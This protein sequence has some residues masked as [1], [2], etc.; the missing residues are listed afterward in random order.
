[1]S[2]DKLQEKIR[3][4]K[5]PTMMELSLS[6]WDIPQ[7]VRSQFESAA[8]AYGA[9]CEM[10]L[11]QMKGWIPGIRV[12]FSSFALLGEEGN[13]QLSRILK[14]ASDCGYYVLLD[15]PEIWSAESAELVIRQIWGE[16][17]LFPC[18][19]V[20]IGCYLGSDIYKPFLPFCEK[21]K[22]DLF[23]SVRSSNKSASEL[24]DLLAGSRLV[25]T[26]AADYVNRYTGKTVGKWS[27]SRVAIASAASSADSLRNLR[28]KYPKLFLLVDGYDYP[29][30]NAK[31]CSYAFDQMGHGA[32][33]CTGKTIGCAWKQNQQEQEDPLKAAQEAADRMK[34]NLTRY[35]TIL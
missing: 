9:Y 10:L 1:M 19:G 6:P 28:K 8:A 21:N 5:N 13:R 27:Y 14:Y 20:L 3:K 25:H 31:N 12:G 24:Q 15:A 11:K 26:A 34:R 23:V 7:M 29:N 22:K 35:V 30:A 32:V 16:G 17:A 2:I 33:V 18:D 4:T